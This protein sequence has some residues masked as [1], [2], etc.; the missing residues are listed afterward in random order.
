MWY[1]GILFAEKRTREDESVST[2]IIRNLHKITNEKKEEISGSLKFF[3]ILE[4][5]IVRA[6]SNTLLTKSVFVFNCC[7]C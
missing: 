4:T 3:R 5:M 7:N 6:R 1:I 2:I